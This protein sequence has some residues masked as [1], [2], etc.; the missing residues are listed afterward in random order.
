MMVCL[1]APKFQS[2]T[3]QDGCSPL[4][5]S[6]GKKI[7]TYLG[8]ALL[9]VAST[10][11]TVVFSFFAL[12]CV[13]VCKPE[14][15]P[16]QV[17]THLLQRSAFFTTWSITHLFSSFIPFVSTKQTDVFACYLGGKFLLPSQITEDGANF[18][19]DNVLKGLNKEDIEEFENHMGDMLTFIACRAI[20]IYL[21]G[22]KQKELVPIFFGEIAKKEIEAFRGSKLKPSSPIKELDS[23]DQFSQ[24]TAPASP[25]PNN[26]LPSS[27]NFLW[28]LKG[29]YGHMLHSPLIGACW[30]RA[31]E[32]NQINNK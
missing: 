26:A 11:E 31:I 15:R 21:W 3:S 12:A 2:F 32:K 5:S 18:L 7:T 16:Y 19:L 20:Y 8:Y 1:L 4:S 30:I 10:V 23:Y 13:F 6:I 14:S 9:S 17:F 28:L 27:Q 25:G 22:E 29:I 24:V